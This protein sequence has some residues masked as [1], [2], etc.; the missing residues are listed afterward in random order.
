METRLEKVILEIWPHFVTREFMLQHAAD[1]KMPITALIEIIPWTA[2]LNL[3][4]QQ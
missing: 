2:Q 3:I 1:S 4:A